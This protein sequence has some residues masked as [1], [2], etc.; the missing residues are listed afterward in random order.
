MSFNKKFFTTGGIV[1][2]S[3][4]AACLTEDVNP[5]TGTSADNGVA[6]Y[7]LDYDGSEASGNYDS[8]ISSSSGL[9]FGVEGKTNTGV[10]FSANNAGISNTNLFLD[11]TAH[12]VSLWI[13]P[14][15]LTATRWQIIYFSN[16]TGHPAFTL[17]KRPNQSTSFHYRNESSSE[18]YFTL[19]NADV[20]YHIVITRNNSGSEVFVNG[21]SIA[22]DSNSMGTTSSSGYNKTTI[23]SN[24][25]Y[26]AEYF[27]GTID[28]IRVFSK[29]LDSTEIATLY[30]SGNG[31]TACVYTATA[32]TADFPSGATAV[33]HYPLDNSSED[34]KGTNDG[35]D[36]NIEYRFGRFGQAA[37]FN[38]S[39]SKIELPSALS[40]GAT[41]DATC[42]SFWFNVGAEVTSSTTGNEIMQFAG[43]STKTGKIA[44]GST[45]GHMSGETFSVTSNVT[46]TYTYSQTNIPA[47][48]NHAVVQWNSSSVK[49]DIYI[50][51]IQHTTY[52]VGTQAQRKFKLKFGNRSSVYYT[53][54]LD[55]VRIFSTALSS[56]QVT[57]LYNEKPEVDTSNFKTVLYEGN[58]S[59]QYVSNVGFQPDLLFL[60]ARNQSYNWSVWDSVRGANKLLQSNTTIAEFNGTNAMN[61]FDANGFTL[62]AGENSNDTSGGAVS[63]VGFCWKGGGEAVQNTQ[64]DITSDVSANTEAGFSIVKYTAGGAANVGHGLDSAPELII[65]KNI[66]ASEQWFVYS[67]ATGL[68]KFLGLNTTT[69]ATSNSGVY[70]SVT[71]TTFTNNISSTSRTYINYCFHSVAGYSKIGSYSGTG[72]DGNQITS[73]GFKPSFILIKRTDSADNWNIVDNRRGNFGLFPDVNSQEL[74]N[75]GAVVFDTDGFTINGGAGGYN[76]GSGTY[77]YMAFK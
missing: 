56:S 49:W 44:L 72:I 43:D 41:T 6:L 59:A 8:D 22:T 47:G 65:T 64:G 31:E 35:T 54:S 20:W 13:K 4:D 14:Q 3:G 37:V 30:N 29:V 18:V 5:F 55:Q 53:G 77:L 32:N 2:S 69:A 73:L 42:I 36:S 61:S 66:D 24:P 19:S 7:T 76:N 60:K 75:S 12:S 51:S 17:G 38:G 50:N 70:T 74:S 45:S 28:Q 9:D 21:N 62:G 63:S 10:R 11:S 40:D 34:N 15:D 27:D 33:A 16:H 46:G 25:S 26:P 71:D 1:A 67:A 68:Q 58:G 48:W 52:T 57:E 39:S 23:G